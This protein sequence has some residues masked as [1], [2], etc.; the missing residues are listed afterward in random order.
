VFGRRRVTLVVH[1]LP[2]NH[3]LS[4]PNASDRLSN[5]P[6]TGPPTGPLSAHQLPSESGSTWLARLMVRLAR[7]RRTGEANVESLRV[8]S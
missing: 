7:P 2:T 4:A 8:T 1:A 6:N 3:P 5:V